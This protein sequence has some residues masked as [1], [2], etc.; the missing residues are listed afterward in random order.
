[1]SAADRHDEMLRMKKQLREQKKLEQEAKRALKA[2]E[3]AAKPTKKGSSVDKQVNRMVTQGKFREL[4]PLEL[5]QT[6]EKGQNIT[7]VLREMKKAG[8]TVTETIAENLKEQFGCAD[9]AR[10]RLALTDADK[11]DCSPRSTHPMLKHRM[12]F[13]FGPTFLH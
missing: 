3:K 11:Q 4:T 2:A 13:E 7:G 5:M 6:N 12:C 8:Q 1:M 9:G 10:A